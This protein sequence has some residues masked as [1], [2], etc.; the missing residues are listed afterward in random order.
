MACSGNCY[1]RTFEY[2]VHLNEHIPTTGSVFDVK[3]WINEL[4]KEG[5]EVVE[6]NQGMADSGMVTAE[7]T[8]IPKMVVQVFAKRGLFPPDPTTE[9]DVE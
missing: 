4:G 2:D 9:P 5:W 7:G 3:S 6:L 1:P 8:K